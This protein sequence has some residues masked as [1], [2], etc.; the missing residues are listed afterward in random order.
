MRSEKGGNACEGGSGELGKRNKKQEA[1][2]KKQDPRN[3]KQEIRNKIQETR[4]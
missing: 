4:W 2:L 1:R 3:K